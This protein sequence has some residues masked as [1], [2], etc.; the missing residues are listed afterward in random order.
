LRNH[1]PLDYHS[2]LGWTEAGV[3]EAWGVEGGVFF[4]TDWVMSASY[5]NIGL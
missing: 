1:A 2:T 5:I 4:N 3:E